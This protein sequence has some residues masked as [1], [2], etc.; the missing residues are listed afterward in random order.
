MLVRSLVIFFCCYC[1]VSCLFFVF[2]ILKIQLQSLEETDF[3]LKKEISLEFLK[4][5]VKYFIFHNWCGKI[6]KTIGDA[7]PIH[8]V[9]EDI[10][11][12]TWA[13][14]KEESKTVFFYGPHSVSAFWLLPRFP[15]QS[16]FWLW[17]FSWETLV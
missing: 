5:S 9:L 4:I 6:L 16:H 1:F 13:I 7:L 17:S 10:R 11:K 3:H 14:Q 15:F 12:P 2:V 8:V